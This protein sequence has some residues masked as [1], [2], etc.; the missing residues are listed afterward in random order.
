MVSD[1]PLA[2]TSDDRDMAMRIPPALR[3]LA[4]AGFAPSV[5]ALCRLSSSKQK[6]F[7]QV[8]LNLGIS[9]LGF[10][11]TKK[12][13]PILKPICLKRGLFGKDI[14]KKGT[15][16]LRCLQAEYPMLCVPTCRQCASYPTSSIFC[17]YRSR[18]EADPGVFGSGSRCGLSHLPDCLPAAAV[19]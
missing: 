12:L 14:N 13:I 16:P 19:L 9:F 5:I 11:L 17:R 1:A 8:L 15:R 6:I 2:L 7:E 4:A 18:R 3:A 10:L